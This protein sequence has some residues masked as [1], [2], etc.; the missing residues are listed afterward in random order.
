VEGRNSNVRLRGKKKVEA[1]QGEPGEV[2]QVFLLGRNSERKM[3]RSPSSSRKGCQTYLHPSPKMR[4]LLGPEKAAEEKGGKYGREGKNK[5][6]LTTARRGHVSGRPET[7]ERVWKE[8]I[9]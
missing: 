8:K 2:G 1:V 4:L 9:R 7:R 3:V 6:G 5:G